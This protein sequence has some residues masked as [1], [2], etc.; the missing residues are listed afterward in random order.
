MTTNIGHVIRAC[1]AT[2]AIL[3]TE[4]LPTTSADW[5]D[6]VER[7]GLAIALVVFFVVTGWRR[8]ARMSE[9]ITRL[10]K[11]L[12]KLA[13]ENAKLTQQ[14]ISGLE[15][16]N[17]MMSEAMRVLDSRTCFAFDSRDQFEAAKAA[18]GSEK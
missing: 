13:G 18:I 6:I 12:S 10:E 9:R 5:T 8:E 1:A 11:D 4:S 3:A 15:R 7:L 16:E 17:N 14:V 2:G